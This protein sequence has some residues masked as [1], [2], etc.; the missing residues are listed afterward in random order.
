MDIIW[1]GRTCFTIKSK[2]GTIVTDP[3]S[4]D[5][6]KAPKLKADIVVS[7]MEVKNEDYLPVE[8]DVKRLD[9]PGEYDVKGIPVFGFRAWNIP[10]SEED[11]GTQKKEVTVFTFELEG[12]KF[13]HLGYLGHKPTD[14]M[15]ANLQNIDVLFVPV[16]GSNAMDAKKAHEVIEEIEPKIVIPMLYKYPGEKLDL[17]NIDEFLKE[18]GV[19]TPTELEKF[20]ISSKGQ[21]PQDHTEFVI[22]KAAIG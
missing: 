15:T 10:K 8:G 3:Y 6:F 19:K 17:N 14:D 18:E 2:D 7:S 1:H 21:L 5:G 20:S 4:L 16:G 22:L 12:V 11:K 13:C 9:W